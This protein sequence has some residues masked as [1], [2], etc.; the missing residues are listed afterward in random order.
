MT[1]F[2]ICIEDLIGFN[3]G[4]YPNPTKGNF[5]VAMNQVESEKIGVAVYDMRGRLIFE[6]SYANNGSFNQE[7]QLVNPQAG[8]YLVKVSDGNNQETKRLIVE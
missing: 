1:I 5:T 4:L 6:Q 2:G 3:F 8:I 7:I